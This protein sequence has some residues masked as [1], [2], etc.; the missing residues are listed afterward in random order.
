MHQYKE[1][2]IWQKAIAFVSDIYKVT[3][4]FPDK[5]KFNLISQINRAAVSIPSN[6]AEGAGRN[7]K[8]EF[9]QFLAIAHGSTYEVETQLIISKNLGYILEED[10]VIILEKLS[11][12]QKMNYSFQQKLTSNY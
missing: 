1:L 9:I 5:E 2:K 7:S 4:I 11:E 12:L 8:K 10:L 6:I 3:S